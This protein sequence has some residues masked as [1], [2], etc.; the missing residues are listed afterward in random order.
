ML[1][2]LQLPGCPLGLH[3][4]TGLSYVHNFVCFSVNL[5]Y[6]NLIIRP[7]EEPTRKNVPTPTAMFRPCDHSSLV[8]DWTQEAHPQTSKQ[9][10]YPLGFVFTKCFCNL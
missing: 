1:Q 2:K 8:V 9:S 10:D 7:T 5:S 4:F 6:I 3:I